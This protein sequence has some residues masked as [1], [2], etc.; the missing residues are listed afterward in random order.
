[1]HDTLD[2]G[3][4]APSAPGPEGLHFINM[5]SFGSRALAPRTTDANIEP[6]P[7]IWAPRHK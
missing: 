5:S 7:F 2:L 4:P 6:T 3:Q 1:M